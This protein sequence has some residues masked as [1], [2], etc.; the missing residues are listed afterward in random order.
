MVVDRT[1]AGLQPHNRVHALLVSERCHRPRI[2]EVAAKRPFAVDRFAGGKCGGDEL[3]MLR[4]LDRHRD[5]VD[6]RLGHQLLGVREH[7]AHAEHFACGT[8]R[9]GAVRAQ[10]ADLVVRQCPQRRDVGG[11]GPTPGGADTDDPDAQ[12]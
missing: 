11:G 3:S 10:R 9:I 4:D 1:L 5:H 6:V 7:R 12:P 2:V 8:C